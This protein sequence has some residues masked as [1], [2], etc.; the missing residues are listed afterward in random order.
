MCLKINK[1]IKN[2]DIVLMANSGSIIN[3]LD[4]HRSGRNESL[5]MV[6]VVDE[7]FKSPFFDGSGQFVDGN[8]QMRRNGVA[9]EEADKRLT[10][11]VVVVEGFGEGKVRGG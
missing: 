1:F 6:V 4:I 9:I 11:D 7:I 8:E 10:N 3:N 2:R 5:M